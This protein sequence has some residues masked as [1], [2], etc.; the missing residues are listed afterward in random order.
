[1]YNVVEAQRQKPPANPQ[2][3]CPPQPDSDSK[4]FFFCNL[5][6]PIVTSGVWS[7][8]GLRKRNF[9]FLHNDSCYGW[10][11]VQQGPSLPT[12]IRIVVYWN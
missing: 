3:Y 2:V 6:V 4:A 11:L 8:V 5:P 12:R 9:L 1:M 10:P 7:F